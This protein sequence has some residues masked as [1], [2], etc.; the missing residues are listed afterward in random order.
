MLVALS[1]VLVQYHTLDIQN[2]GRNGLR[3]IVVAAIP[4][5]EY[6]TK[7]EQTNVNSNKADLEQHP[8]GKIDQEHLGIR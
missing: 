2:R 7:V 4:L 8:G 5:P 1:R 6:S 3:Q